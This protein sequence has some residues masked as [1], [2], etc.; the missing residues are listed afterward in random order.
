MNFSNLILPS[1]G[2][3]IVEGRAISI[4]DLKTALDKSYS[5]TKIKS[6]FGD[7]EVDSNLTTKETQVYNNPKTGQV[8]VVHRGTQGLR[9][10]FTDIAYT[11][12][13]YK[14]KRFKDANKIQK[15]A[16]KKYGAEN[17]STLGHSLGSLVS[18]D[19]GSNSKEIINYNKP[20]IQ[21]SKK[22]D[23]EYNVS[24]QNDPFS[25][26]H[27]PKKS[28][29]HIKIES[30]TVDPIHEHSIHRLNNLDE[31]LMIGEGIKK[32]KI[33]ELKQAIKRHN[34]QSTKKIKGYGK[35]KKQELRT[36]LMDIY[37]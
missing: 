9:D 6:G 24:T 11:A 1:V 32:M 35:M 3:G 7:F 20:I 12:T 14:G 15:L 33:S 30:K 10:V 17:V 2:S 5:K 16:E 19:V 28:D 18:S 37:C 29:N 23:N 31:N 4:G 36:K 27:K 22:R 25:W 8:L 26:F 34:R 21:W 13:G